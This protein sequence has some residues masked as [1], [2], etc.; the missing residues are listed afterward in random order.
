MK[1]QQFIVIF[2][3]GN[4]PALARDGAQPGGSGEL[5]A[6]LR[7]FDRDK[8]GKLSPDELKLARQAHNR[9][10]R[11]AEPNPGR[12]REILVRQEREFGRRREKEF[13]AGGDGALDEGERREMREV[14]KKIAAR[15]GE[16]RVMIT[17]KYD[18]NDD[19]ELNERERNASREE[20]ERLRRE[21]ED[22]C[23][24]EWR[25]RKALKPAVNPPP[26]AGS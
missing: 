10:G 16:L 23:M 12:W 4:V 5:A 17:A 22:R 8:D 2:L 15:Y 26:S 11:E 3:V 19:G 9:G 25:Q 6:P 7:K 18:R 1:L 21:A 13:D 20:S 24:N 14:W